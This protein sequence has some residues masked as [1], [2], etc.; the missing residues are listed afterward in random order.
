MS[1]IEVHERGAVIVET[2]LILPLLIMLMMGIAEFGLA[3][4][5]STNAASTVRAATLEET[6]GDTTRLIDFKTIERVRATT[7]SLDDL[8]WLM[9]Y[10]VASTDSGGPPKACE[11]AAAA[12]SFGST[13]IQGQCTIFHGSYVATA[14]A[15][16]FVDPACAGEP[17]RFLCPT[18]RDTVFAPTDRV[19]VAVSIDHRWLTGIVPGGGI[20][21][22]DHSV[23]YRLPTLGDLP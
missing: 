16:D 13:G 18:T 23:S 11:A 7:D 3:W 17:D 22:S 20:Q 8:D 4:R 5:S 15:A 10:R 19:G 1:R 12:L 6:R 9:I 2:A 14:T 21:L